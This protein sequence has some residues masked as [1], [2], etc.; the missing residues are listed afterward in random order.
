[1]TT[2]DPL[3]TYHGPFPP[4]QTKAEP[5]IVCGKPFAPDSEYV[6]VQIFSAA[7]G[8]SFLHMVHP[9]CVSPEPEELA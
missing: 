9:E 7:F 3:I 4:T 6:V 5:C 1:M 2:A 8:G